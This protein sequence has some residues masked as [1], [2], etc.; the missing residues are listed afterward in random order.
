MIQLFNPIKGQLDLKNVFK[1]GYF[2]KFETY[3]LEIMSLSFPGL[4]KIFSI[5][6][7][8]SW[9]NFKNPIISIT[10]VIN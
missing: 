5:I 1:H 8:S 7:E 10:T 4:V 2:T 9:L 3:L 6:C